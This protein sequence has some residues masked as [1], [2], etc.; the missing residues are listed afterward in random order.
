MDFYWSF[1][2]M[3]ADSSFLKKGVHLVTFS[4]LVAKTQIDFLLIRKNLSTQHKLLLMDLEIKKVRRMRS[5]E[6]KPKI[7]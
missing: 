7:K 1:G 2:L 6:D 4:S 5:V 3:L